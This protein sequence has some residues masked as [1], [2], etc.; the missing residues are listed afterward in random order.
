MSAP[1]DPE[2]LLLDLDGTLLNEQG[3]VH[4]RNR[5]AL[6]AAER[7]GVRVMIVTGRSELATAPLLGELGLES[8]A[9]VY[10][11]AG[12]WCPK[13]RR[14]IEERILSNRT[15]R[16]ALEVGRRRGY[17]MISMCAGVKYAL[18]PETETE[19]DAVRLLTGLV[20]TD[21]EG[22]DAEF[23]IRITFFSEHCADSAAC[24]REIEE[25]IGQ[26]AYMTHFALDS[27]PT[28]RQSPVQVVDLHPPCRGKGEAL[29]HLEER[30]GIEASRVVAVGDAGNDLPMLRRAGLSCA[31]ENAVPEVLEAADRVIGDNDSAAIAELVGEL[32]G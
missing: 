31:M 8:P 23:T 11:G 13:E 28:H 4:P 2:A 12:I 5:E 29:R 10:N 3:R 22:L 18:E 25:G 27:L 24:C 9:V 16:R 14:L 32:F 15:R 21:P 7:D 30:F 20:Y 1:P 19:R 26:P 17:R 6:R